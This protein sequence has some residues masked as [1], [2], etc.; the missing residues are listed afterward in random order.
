[1]CRHGLLGFMN[2]LKSW[3]IIKSEA[4]AQIIVN[5]C[6]QTST[7]GICFLYVLHVDKYLDHPPYTKLCIIVPN[8]V[9]KLQLY[10]YIIKSPKAPCHL[11]RIILL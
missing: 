8:Y 2:I 5:T 1:M 9:V 11:P 3:I 7:E 4:F 10:I 6:N